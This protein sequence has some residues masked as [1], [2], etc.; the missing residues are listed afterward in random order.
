[1]RDSVAGPA[2]RVDPELAP[3]IHRE[4]PPS[5][6]LPALP[7]REPGARGLAGALLARHLRWDHRQHVGPQ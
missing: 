7:S 1:M 4:R 6:L 5:C 3:Q 2:P